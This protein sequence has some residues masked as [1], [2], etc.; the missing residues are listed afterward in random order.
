MRGNNLFPKGLFLLLGLAVMP[1]LVLAQT[2]DQLAA[3]NIAFYN[4]ATVGSSANQLRKIAEAD[5]AMIPA[6]DS[7][8]TALTDRLTLISYNIAMQA[9]TNLKNNKLIVQNDGISFTSQ[10]NMLLQQAEHFVSVIEDKNNPITV[11]NKSIGDTVNHPNGFYQTAAQNLLNVEQAI[12]AKYYSTTIINSS[13]FTQPGFAASSGVIANDT[14]LVGDPLANSGMGAI[15]QYQWLNNQ[16]VLDSTGN[17][18]PA[19][20]QPLNHF[21]SQMVED[22]GLL[23]AATNPVTSSGASHPQSIYIYTRATAN[24]TVWNQEFKYTFG[25]HA[26]SQGISIAASASNNTVVVGEP[27]NGSVHVFRKISGKWS[28]IFV[29][30]NSA[31]IGIVFGKSVATDGTYIFIGAPNLNSAANVSGYVYFYKENPANNWKFKDVINKSTDVTY[32][33]LVA[34]VD[35]PGNP[36]QPFLMIGSKSNIYVDLVHTSPLS[37]SEQQLN[38]ILPSGVSQT[39]TIGNVVA[40][41]HRII[42][43]YL[44]S[45]NPNTSLA[46]VYKLNPQTGSW[47]FFDTFQTPGTTSTFSGGLTS[48]DNNSTTFGLSAAISG[49]SIV[50]GQPPD[51]L[52]VNKNNVNVGDGLVQIMAPIQIKNTATNTTSTPSST[53]STPVATPSPAVGGYIS[54]SCDDPAPGNQRCYCLGTEVYTDNGYQTL[55]QPVNSGNTD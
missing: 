44:P 38:K 36:A 53:D 3:A 8:F 39:G 22:N 30:R 31:A 9:I 41:N 29:I 4:L 25:S 16:W 10:Y 5:L 18:V 34:L 54:Y 40:K 47:L 27:A 12:L 42:A 32:G 49:K 48:H 17:I 6:S 28:Q 1:S 50:I 43:Q 19:D 52:H 2:A 26:S 7:Q 23:V 20:I 24:K 33:S 15:Y 21:A 13:R 45:N 35:I 14:I 37:F 51:S 11:T 55:C 46:L